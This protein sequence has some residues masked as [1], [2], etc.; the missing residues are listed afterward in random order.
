VPA[1]SHSSI[2]ARNRCSFSS[3]K[4]TMPPPLYDGV[5]F[6]TSFLLRIRIPGVSGPPMNLWGE[7]KT[8]SLYWRWDFEVGTF[9]DGYVPCM[10]T[11]K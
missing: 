9:D 1:S 11:N 5:R 8:A 10:S 3:T 4:K 6:W 2:P 7:M